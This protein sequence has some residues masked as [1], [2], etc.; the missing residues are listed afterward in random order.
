MFD[1][2]LVAKFLP[3]SHTT[4]NISLLLSDR[5]VYFLLNNLEDKGQ[6]I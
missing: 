4:I 2:L 5:N 6:K 1:F 3:C